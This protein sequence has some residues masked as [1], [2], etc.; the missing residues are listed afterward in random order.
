MKVIGIY[1][2][3]FKFFYELVKRL[4]DQEEPFVSIGRDLEV[5][6]QVGVV[7]TTRKEASKIGFPRVVSE[8]DPD[9]A[10]EMARC[11]LIGGVHYRT[12]I[13]GIDPGKSTGIAVFGE[14]KMLA[15]ET[16]IVP[17]DVPATVARLLSCLDYARSLARIGHG[18]PTNRNRIING[19]WKLMDE[20]EVVDESRT[21]KKTDQPDVDAAIAIAF[22]KGYRLDAPPQVLPT[23]GEVKDIQRLSRIESDGAVT[24]SADLA[25]AVAKGELT[26]KDAILAQRAKLTHEAG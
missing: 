11:L 24:I 14:G 17:E 2:E 22:T 19:L 3:D 16:V 18:D 23:P 20:M 7:I 21:T 26:L 13:V 15:T 9:L 10:I 25:Q 1:T 4:K 6:P 8:P 12:V 5:P